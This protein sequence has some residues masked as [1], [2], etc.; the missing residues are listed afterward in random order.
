MPSVGSEAT[1]VEGR[2]PRPRTAPPMLAFIDMPIIIG[3]LIVSAVF[4]AVGVALVI[5]VVKAIRRPG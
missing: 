4:L 3:I 5:F 1:V 2:P